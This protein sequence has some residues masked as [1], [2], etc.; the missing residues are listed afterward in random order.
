MKVFVKSGFI[1]FAFAMLSACRSGSSFPEKSAWSGRVELGD[2]VIV[3]LQMNL[4]LSGTKPSGYFV[5]GDEKAPI[6]EIT[7]DN[8]SVVLGFSE[9]GAEIR[10]SWDGEE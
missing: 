5:I 4:D 10:A 7:R 2:G 6:P 8:Q 1:I 9:Y 3:P